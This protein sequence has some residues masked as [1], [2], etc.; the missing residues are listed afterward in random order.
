MGV[1][2]LWLLISNWSWFVWIWLLK[3]SGDPV[4]NWCWQMNNCTIGFEC[5]TKG[6]SGR[7][8]G[9]RV[10]WDKSQEE[11]LVKKEVIYPSFSYRVRVC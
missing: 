7:R 5:G 11:A 4:K 8:E 1:F 10:R 9:G 3:R 2:W 6:K